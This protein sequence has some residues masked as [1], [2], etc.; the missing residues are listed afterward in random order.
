M[1]YINMETDIGVLAMEENIID[2]KKMLNNVLQKLSVDRGLPINDILNILIDTPKEYSADKD[3]NIDFSNKNIQIACIYCYRF[4]IATNTDIKTAKEYLH[5][6]AKVENVN[7]PRLS[8]FVFDEVLR[9]YTNATNASI[10]YAKSN[11]KAKFILDKLIEK[12]GVDSGLPNV[13][14]IK[15]VISTHKNDPKL[16][17]SV[18]ELLDALT[19]KNGYKTSDIK[20]DIFD[21][22]NEAE[23][24]KLQFAI[25]NMNKQDRAKLIRRV[26]S[27][28]HTL[29]NVVKQEIISTFKKTGKFEDIF[30]FTL[31]EN[32]NSYS[33]KEYINIPQKISLIVA[34]YK[35]KNTSHKVFYIALVMFC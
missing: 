10:L 4:R 11:E 31:D 30:G 18:S 19:N 24:E 8:M 12:T 5:E 22:I 32:E 1:I 35:E 16:I 20:H 25:D 23:H 27:D 7:N 29:S 13:K 33:H 17:L 26:S 6:F 34:N 15:K 2:N 14:T 3:I 28:D 9:S 21:N